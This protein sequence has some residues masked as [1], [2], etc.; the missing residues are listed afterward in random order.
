MKTKSRILSF[1]L[2]MIMALTIAAPVSAQMIEPPG[3]FFVTSGEYHFEGHEPAP[4][5]PDSGTGNNTGGSDYGAGTNNTEKET[6]PKEPATEE[7]ALESAGSDAFV[8]DCTPEQAA[9]IIA[10]YEFVKQQIASQPAFQPFAAPG[11]SGTVSWSWGEAVNI[12]VGG[13][14]INNLPNISLSTANQP[15]G[16]PFCVQF[17]IDPGGSYT[18]SAGSNNQVLRLLVAYQKGQASATGVQLALWAAIEGLP[19]GSHPQASAAV[20]AANGVSTDGYTYLLWTSGS[21]QPFVT[22]DNLDDTPE[23]PDPP[24]DPDP[25]GENP[26]T[27]TEVTTEQST[28]TEVRSSTTYEY[29]DAI[30][31]I[32]VAKRD[33][34]ARSLDGAIFR[35][36][37][38]FANG[39]RGGTSA[40]EVYNGSR[41]FTWTH[42]RDDNRPAR[43]TVTEVRAPDGYIADPTPKTAIVHP[44]YTRIT[45]VLTHTITITT[46][47]TTTSV[48]DIDSGEVLATSSASASA[49]TEL[50]PPTVQEYV[51]FVAGDRET[52]LTFVNTPAPCSLTIYKHEK[53]NYSV[54][55]QGARFRV[56][57][58][59]PN[60]SAQVW[61]L[62][63][64]ASGII[65][66]DLPYA[67]TLIVEELEAPFGYVIGSVSMWEVVVARGEHKRI[68]ISNDKKADIIVFKKDAQ[69]GQFLAGAVIKAT[70]LRAHTP[71]YDQNVSYTGTTDADGRVLFSNMIPGEYR[72]EEQSPPQYYLGTTIIHNVSVFDGSNEPVTVTFENEPW[73]GLT[74]R[75]VD[76][77]NGRG[78]QGAVFKLYEGTAAETTKFLGDFISNE[79]GIVVIQN[80]ESDKYYTIVEAQPPFGYFLDDKHN[81]QTILIKPEAIEKNLNIVFRNLP[82][83]KLLIEK[84]DDATGVRLPGAVFRVAQRASAE[85]VEVTTGVNGTVLLEN[86][87]VGWYQVTEIR[88]PSGYILDNTAR[89][90]E[91]VAGETAK[92]VINNQKQ[93]TLTI[94]KVDE[95][96]GQGLSGAVLRVTKQGAMEYQDV[97]TGVNGTARLTG[98]SPGWH[99]VT[100]IKAPNNYILDSTPHYVELK[101]GVDNELV[102]INRKKPSLKI[103]KL[104]TVTKQ[105]LQYVTFRIQYKNG[106]TIG[107]FTT[108]EDGEIFLEHINPGLVVITETKA[109]DGY[110]IADKEKEVLVEWGKIA[111][112][113]FLNQP[114][115]PIIIKKIDEITGAAISGTVFTVA[116]VNGEFIGEYT[117]GRNGFIAVTGIEPGFYLVRESKAAPGYIRD[118]VPKVVE[119]KYNSAAEVQFTNKP[120]TGLQ[121]RKV[122]SV[123]GQPI[124]DVQFLITEID[125]RRIGTFRTDRDGIINLPAEHEEKYVIVT[126]VAPAAGYKHDPVPRTLKLESGKL[127]IVEFRN[128]PYPQLTVQKLC[129]ETNQP[130][131]GVRFKFLDRFGREIGIFTTNAQGQIHLT[132]MDEGDYFIQEHQAKPG[133]VLDAASRRVALQWGKTATVEVK[134]TPMG[135][136]RILKIDAVTKKPVPGTTFLIYDSRNNILGEFVSNDK[137]IVDIPRSIAAQRLRVKETKAAPGYV[138]DEQIRTIDIKPGETTEIV[139][140]NQPLRG[141]IQ[142]V[143]KAAADNPITK[144]KAGAVLEGAAFDVFDKDLNVVDRLTTDSR[145]IA[146]TGPLPLGTYAIKESKAPAYFFT[147]GKVFYAEVKLHGDMIRFEVQNS[148]MDISVT[149]EKR[150]NVEVVAG[151]E[152]RYDF[153]NIANT[154]NTSL[155]GFYLHD[156]LP[157]EAVRLKTI[158]TGT[159]N[160]SLTYSVTY[161][162]NQKSNYRVLAANLTS[163]TSHTL[164]CTPAALKLA[165][166]EYIT[167]IRFEFGTVKAGFTE[168]EAPVFVVNTLATLPD[169]YR[170]VN[171]ADV[172]GKTGEMWVVAKDTWVTVNLGKPKGSLPKTGF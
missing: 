126:E 75:K 122:D 134:N 154:S 157:T 105:P 57:Y 151:D 115:N 99:I 135:S 19:F 17:G 150:G 42:P 53:G 1:I 172:G 82:K 12:N 87:N 77:T 13:Y 119:L 103:I 71:P 8:L 64:N 109:R 145:G 39:Q 121:I 25:D 102:I 28:R 117:T 95:S 55:L 38:E 90:V 152:M 98:L 69:T 133:Y 78:L 166:N 20:S 124:G 159:W 142:I 36:D 80:L 22:L 46:T 84:I 107:E 156:Q 132:G 27:R 130:L 11:D 104:D 127:N 40:F 44:T 59:D 131:E 54:A 45:K 51:D 62:A 114:K 5:V 91:L 143:K 81:V 147:E 21:G 100:E 79:N 65:R 67:G 108:N 24:V 148:P 92:L 125:G 66:I 167:D 18:A 73:T 33:D 4:I 164:D 41:L 47:T 123:T 2:A 70:L 141:Q 140:E 118:G 161:K 48:I 58:A 10:F 97:T 30:G 9:R 116:K 144:Q 136:L 160:E 158:F 34:E 52:T 56:R 137:G 7:A 162:T 165:A 76:A 155:D 170:I 60:V 129:A 14:Y 111:T 168:V 163:Q 96:T 6:K 149:V 3:D 26:N 128:Q 16:K 15:I 50:N 112:V 31:Q 68:D 37:I 23:P 153:T 138:L 29:S 88:S 43:V 139:W 169:G 113:E 146:T 89:D 93:P 101:P 94:R 86:L 171:R 63:T 32:T 49:E 72:I 110:I 106:E 74:I 35:I 85:Y 83:P 120:L 61:T